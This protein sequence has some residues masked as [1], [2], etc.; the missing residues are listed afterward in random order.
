MKSRNLSTH[1]ELP[2]IEVVLPVL[3]IVEKNIQSLPLVL[4]RLV[5]EVLEQNIEVLFLCKLLRN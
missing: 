3:D 2:I 5:F 1:Q 4:K